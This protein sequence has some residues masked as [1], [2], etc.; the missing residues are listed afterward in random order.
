M[1]DRA[2]AVSVPVPNVAEFCTTVQVPPATRSQ[3][4]VGVLPSG[5][6]KLQSTDP[7]FGGIGSGTRPL[8]SSTWTVI[9]NVCGSLIALLSVNGVMSTS[10]AI[11]VLVAVREPSVV[12]MT[13]AGSLVV[14]P[15]SW[16]PPTVA[17]TPVMEMVPVGMR[18]TNQVQHSDI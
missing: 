7:E 14:E 8:P 1:T 12:A 5:A 15:V 18:R 2:V 6:A 10:K 9:V 17:V 11:Q 3:V 13:V 16:L 4:P